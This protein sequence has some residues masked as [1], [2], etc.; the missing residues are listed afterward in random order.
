MNSRPHRP[1]RAVTLDRADQT[2]TSELAR[3]PQSLA[4]LSRTSPKLVPTRPLPAGREAHS[5]RMRRTENTS[6]SYQTSACSMSLCR[7]FFSNGLLT[8]PSCCS[9]RLPS[10]AS[11]QCP[12]SKSSYFKCQSFTTETPKK[13]AKAGNISF[14][15]NSTKSSGSSLIVFFNSRLLYPG[16]CQLPSALGPLS[17]SILTASRFGCI[18][19]HQVAELFR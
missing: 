18:S 4:N 10:K 13:L 5:D 1:T 15:L 6:H 3:H 9:F 12:F 8:V 16:G 17:I 19:R 2:R 14:T 11:F 7:C